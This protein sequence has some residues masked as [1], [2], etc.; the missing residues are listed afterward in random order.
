MLNRKTSK[1]LNIKI[2]LLILLTVVVSIKYL[3]ADIA[4]NVM[5]FLKY[6]HP[7][8]KVTENIPD[9]L[10]EIVG[11]GTAL[12]WAIYFYRL[13][14]KKNDNLTKFLRVAATALPFAYMLK[15]F[16]KFVFGRTDPRV[17]LFTNKPL[18]FHWF[19]KIESGSFPSGH[20][21]VFTAFGVAVLLYYP[22][23]RKYIVIVLILLGILLIGT[24][25]HFLSDVIAGTYFG[26]LTTYLIK[27]IYEKIN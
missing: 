15:T 4:K 27:Y 11:V 3:D 14:K 19:D 13:Y 21:T 17:W 16:L 8:H 10:P 2:T 20:M 12:M 7:L 22:Q 5:A 24:D 1:Y 25:Y 18:E 26:C 23:F 9:L 6:I